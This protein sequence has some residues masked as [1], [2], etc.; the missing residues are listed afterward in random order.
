MITSADNNVSSLPTRALRTGFTAVRLHYSADPARWTPSR[1]AAIRS[2]MP[3]WRWRKEYEIDFAARGGQKVYDMFDPHIH[4]RPAGDISTRRHCYRVIDHGRRNPTC[5][6]WW[7]ETPRRDL[8]FYREFYRPDATI[9]DN[10]RA[11]LA[12]ESNEAIRATLIDPSTSRRLDNA[13]TTIADEYARHGLATIPADNAMLPGIEA[14]SACLISALA[15]HS[16]MHSRAHDYFAVRDIDLDALKPIAERRA[17][18]LD[19]SMTNTIRELT[20][21][22]WDARTSTDSSN[23]AERPRDVDDHAADCVR[24]ACM[25]YSATRRRIRSARAVHLGSVI[26]P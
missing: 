14:V 3:G 9:A 18:Y 22:A 5:C 8:C 15:R 6:L 13:N 2:A 11:I 17:L 19:P 21:L 1:I 24:Y 20:E 16:I 7:A 26:P 25:R 10:C 23:L 12:A 4:V